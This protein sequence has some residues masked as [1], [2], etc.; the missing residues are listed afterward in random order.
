[1]LADTADSDVRSNVMGRIDH[2]PSGSYSYA[3]HRGGDPIEPDL[4]TDRA[5]QP[6]RQ[7]D[8]AVRGDQKSGA[9]A[10]GGFLIR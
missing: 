10:Q 9:V 8:T 3:L 4:L 2:C 5:L 7:P 6:P 1:M